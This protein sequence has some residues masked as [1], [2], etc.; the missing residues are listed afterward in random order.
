MVYLDTCALVDMADAT[1]PR[2]A[3]AIQLLNLFQRYQGSGILWLATSLWS[4]TECHSILYKKALN[5]R[6]VPPPPRR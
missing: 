5:R 3:N 1:R 6:G 2:Y 4:I